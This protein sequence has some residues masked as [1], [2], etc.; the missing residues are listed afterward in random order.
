M[1]LFLSCIMST[2]KHSVCTSYCSAVMLM[3]VYGLEF[4]CIFMQTHMYG[5]GLSA[6]CM[7]LV[8]QS[9]VHAICVPAWFQPLPLTA[10]LCL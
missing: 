6:V 9:C 5:A 1:K 8:S 10:D 7:H 3:I 4:R 2:S